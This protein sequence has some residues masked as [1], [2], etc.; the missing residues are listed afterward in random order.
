M[1]KQYA[2]IL[3]AVLVMMMTMSAVYA[4]TS[5]D[6]EGECVNQ[7]TKAFG[8]DMVTESAVYLFSG[9]LG[10]LLMVGLI[11]VITAIISYFAFNGF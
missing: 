5:K 3:V 8:L 6:E 7:P 2:I 1:K 11:V 4:R 9:G 10:P